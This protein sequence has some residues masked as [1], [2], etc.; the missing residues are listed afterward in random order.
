[1]TPGNL[2]DVVEVEGQSSASTGRPGRLRRLRGSGMARSLWNILDQVVASANNFLIQFVVT[3]AFTKDVFGAFAIAFSVFSISTGFFRALATS[4][5]GMRFAGAEDR[6]FRRAASSA[7]AL[8][9]LGAAVLGAVLVLMGLFL[10]FTDALAHVF[11]ALG[12]VLPGLMLQ[13]AWRQVFFA[14]LRPAAACLIDVSWIVLQ[15]VG[16]GVLVL[17]ADENRISAFTA[18]W[19]GAAYLTSVIGMA[20]L[21]LRPRVAGALAWLREQYSVTRYLVPEFVIIQTGGQLAP[22]VAAAV[23]T[24]DAAGALRGANLVT[25]P[26]TIVST[27]LMS[28]AVPELTRRRQQMDPRRWQLVAVAISGLVVAVS[29]V[30]G[31]IVLLLPTSVGELV[32]DDTWAA[33]RTVLLATIVGQAGSAVTVGCAAVLYATEGAKVTMRLHVVFAVFLVVLSTAGSFL[34]GAQ[35]TAWGIAIAFWLVAPWWFVSVRR[36]VRRPGSDVSDVPAP[37]VDAV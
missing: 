19:G 7:I 37:P 15:L 2:G 31:T 9:G 20:L 16:L 1:V 28:F 26:A 11:V 22:V 18:V 29:L 23:T 8:T 34:H 10:P 4:P 30:W 3:H 17:V 27:G 13:D 12:F 35:G 33:A 36:H 21:H 14:R 24:I 5:V 25:V 6:E 32:L